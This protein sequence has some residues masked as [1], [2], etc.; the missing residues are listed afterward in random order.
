[1]SHS[2]AIVAFVFSVAALGCGSADPEPP[3][4]AT[5]TPAAPLPADEMEG[6]PEGSGSGLE[7]SIEGHRDWTAALAR[8]E[9]R[10]GE[11][12]VRFSITGGADADWIQLN[13]TFEDVA[14]SMGPHDVELTSPLEGEQVANASLDGEELYSRSGHVMLTLSPDGRID[15]GFEIVLARGAPSPDTPP[16]AEATPLSGDFHGTWVLSCQSRLPGHR[17]L[18]SGGEYCDSLEF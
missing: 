5:E 2:R 13:F 3:L 12:D 15:G 16:D 7:L 10:E 9:I 18:V 8:L 17:T 14:S 6:A 11:P 1:M 4:T